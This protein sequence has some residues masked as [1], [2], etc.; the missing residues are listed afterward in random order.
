MLTT[1]YFFSL[2]SNLII[3]KTKYNIIVI[4]AITSIITTLILLIVY[5]TTKICQTNDYKDN[6]LFEVTGPKMCEGGPY[7]IS[8]ASQ[9]IKDYCNKLWSTPEGRQ[10]IAQVSCQK[11]G[12]IGR[13][14]HWSYTP[15]SNDK[16]Q[17][18]RCNPPYLNLNDPC[19]L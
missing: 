11:P 9:E 2:I 3:N 10:E 18:E 4:F 7:M 14:V 6:F 16:W 12:F 15:E 19:P 1:I 5:K 13:P 8:S 17:N